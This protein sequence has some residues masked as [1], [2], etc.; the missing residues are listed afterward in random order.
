MKIFLAALAIADDLGAILVIAVFYTNELHWDQLLYSA[1]ILALLISMNFLGVKKLV[2]Y[3]IPGLFLWYF[4]HHSGIHATI[5]GVL[6]ALTIPTNKTAVESPLEKLE[7]LLVRPVNFIIMLI[8]AIAN[9]NI[10]FENKMLEGLYSPLGLGIILGLVVGKPLGITLFS[11]FSVQLG[12]SSLPSKANWKHIIGLGLLA[13]IGF[14]MSIFIALLSLKETEHQIGAKFSI[15]VASVLAGILGYV[16][17][18]KLNNKG[19]MLK[20]AKS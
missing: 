3:I 4:I 7:H 16:F 18:T 17:L 9:T 15:L 10:R 19:K 5:A 6:L 2:F 20:H 12:L 8:F 14:T 13:G 1:G 11:W